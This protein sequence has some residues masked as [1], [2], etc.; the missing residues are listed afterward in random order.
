MDCP[1]CRSQ[2]PEG[3]NFC[4]SC[5]AKV[6]STGAGLQT[7]GGAFIGGAV[8]TGG[9]DFIGRDQAIYGSQ[10]RTGDISGNKGLAIG[11]GAQ[12]ANTE[13]I[14][15]EELAK[16]FSAIYDRIQARPPDPNTE[17]PEIAD[18]VKK[19]EE[20]TGKGEQANPS[21]LER[22]LKTLALMA[23]DILD[24]TVATLTNPITGI[25]TVIRKVAEKAKAEAAS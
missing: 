10:V 16:L 17:K 4:P 22:L 9:G 25:A 5:G 14:S 6:P 13:A 11:D 3:A 18:T 1:N 24:V 2:V 15:A 12:A 23:P 20:E 7:G 19:I 8:D 21:R